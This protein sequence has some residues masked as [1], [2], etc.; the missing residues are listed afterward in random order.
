MAPCILFVDE[1]EK[2][3]AGIGGQGDSGVSTRLFGTL[4]TWLAEHESDV[5]F[6]GTANDISKLPPEFTR[7]ERLD[8]VFFLDLPA[9]A[10]RKAIWEMYR[11]EFGIAA[12]QKQPADDNWTGAEIR[13]C[14]RLG[15]AA[16]SAA[17]RRREADRP[18]RR[19]RRGGDREAADVGERTVP[20]VGRR[21]HLSEGIVRS[22]ASAQKRS[23]P[24]L[25]IPQF[26]TPAPRSHPSQEESE[27][28]AGFSLGDLNAPPAD[29]YQRPTAATSAT[30]SARSRMPRS[31]SSTGTSIRTIRHPMSC[32]SST[33]A[34]RDALSSG[35]SRRGRSRTSRGRTKL[36]PSCNSIVAR[37][38]RPFR[39]DTLPLQFR[40]H[41]RSITNTIGV[42]MS[43][44]ADAPPQ[45]HA[46]QAPSQRLRTTM[47]AARLSF[48]WFGVRQSLTPAQKA[49][50]A[51][52]FGAE[53]E[54]LS[55][56]KKLIDTKH[57]A[58]RAVT[59]I[60]GRVQSVWKGMTTALS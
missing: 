59:A 37:A 5:F 26:S 13:A 32:K 8:A 6:I 4:L 39:P 10:G 29:R 27:S 48:T 36:P 38:L 30:C 12:N 17:R 42:L 53:G 54:Y 40:F 9:E 22:P 52:S 16:R 1:L 18:G 15:G 11:R 51:E 24:E 47:A 35:A 34:D 2:G 25:T 55:A 44:L 19:H 33:P 21:R 46:H 56:G 14:C 50:A 7:A 60:R 43:A 41:H 20:V 57:P 31:C 3:L 45:A 49:L 28:L 58:F 23:V